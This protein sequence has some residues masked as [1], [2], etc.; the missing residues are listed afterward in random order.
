MGRVESSVSL[1]LLLAGWLVLGVC[2]CGGN[3]GTTPIEYS[4]YQ[5]AELARLAGSLDP[6][7]ASV[8]LIGYTTP[9]GNDFLAGVMKACEEE[10]KRAKIRSAVGHIEADLMALQTGQGGISPDAVRRALADAPGADTI[11]SFAG[12]PQVA[13]AAGPRWVV[14]SSDP[15]GAR[16]AVESGRV[17]IAAFPRMGPPVAGPREEADDRFEAEYEILRAP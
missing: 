9:T 13:D 12:L 4:K 16:A 11:I 2:G 5:G 10:L 14:L 6:R 15:L 3:S 8:L 17:R 1:R 7:P